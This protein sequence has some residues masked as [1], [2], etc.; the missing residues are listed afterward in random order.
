[1]PYTPSP[2]RCRYTKD[3]RLVD[4]SADPWASLQ[5]T[6]LQLTGDFLGP[7]LGK[8]LEV[9]LG[10]VIHRQDSAVG[11]PSCGTLIVG[12]QCAALPGEK[13]VVKIDH[14][15]RAR[16][17]EAYAL[18]K[19]RAKAMSDERHNSVLNHVP[20]LR[21]FKMLK[22]LP[23]EHPAGYRLSQLLRSGDASLRWENAEEP[24]YY[25]RRT[26]DCLLQ[27]RLHPLS[28]LVD[29]REIAQVLSDTVRGAFRSL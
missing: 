1:M 28:A 5:R 16:F 22:G 8:T 15:P 9:K 27:E 12:A 20:N 2:P 14:P 4:A 18:L 23:E 3:S 25:E 19:L 24:F 7:H 29:E 10:G 17:P 6:K 21:G 13:L 11:E 26:L